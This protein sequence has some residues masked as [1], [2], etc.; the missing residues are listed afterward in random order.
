MNRKQLNNC[1]AA[2]VCALMNRKQLNDCMT[3]SAC[4]HTHPLKRQPEL[5][6]MTSHF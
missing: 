3:A 6:Y 1:V 5:I 2:S 4:A